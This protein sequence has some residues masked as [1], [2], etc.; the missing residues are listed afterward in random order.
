MLTISEQDN[1]EHTRSAEVQSEEL[2][3]ASERA[4]VLQACKRAKPL[5]FALTA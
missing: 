1:R 4:H 3:C 2:S 5:I